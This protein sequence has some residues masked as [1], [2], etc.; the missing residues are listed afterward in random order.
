MFGL[1]GSKKK[2]VQAKILVVDDEADL[3]STIRRH[4]E[5]CRY[6]V[7]TASD[8]EEAL[9][10][11]VEERPDLILLDT[12]MPVMDGHEVLERIRV[13]PELR[14]IP[15]IMVTAYCEAKDIAAISSYGVADFVAKPFDFTELVEKITSALDK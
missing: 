6:E 12:A 14:D 15:V 5:W 2:P 10:K 1:F 9:E 11:A 3:V 8:G 4:L 13:H 7:A